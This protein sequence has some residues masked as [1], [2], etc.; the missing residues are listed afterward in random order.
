MA[1]RCFLRLGWDKD[2]QSPILLQESIYSNVKYAALSKA[3][4]QMALDKA[5]QLGI[6][7]IEKDKY[8]AGHGTPYV[9]TFSFLGSDYPYIYSDAAGGIVDG[10]K[11]FDIKNAYLVT[12]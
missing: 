1:A 12:S 6:P 10:L 7:L 3:M 8:R 4:N 5:Q 2:K 11:G 9:G